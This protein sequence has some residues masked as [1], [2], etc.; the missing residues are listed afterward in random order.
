M[1]AHIKAKPISSGI[2]ILGALVFGTATLINPVLGVAGFSAMGPVAGSTAAAWQSSIGIVQAGSFFAWC[3]S[4]AMGGAAAGAIVGA[5][6]AGVAAAG[7]GL[8]NEIRGGRTDE[9]AAMQLVWSVFS[10]C[11]R[12]VGVE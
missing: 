1:V 2:T 10:E 8:M 7:L 11:V 6:G 4:A 12:K 5:Q 9:E 3:Q